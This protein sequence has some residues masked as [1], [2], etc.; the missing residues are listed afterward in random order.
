M[1]KSWEERPR[2]QQFKASE[3]CV[4]NETAK[5]YDCDVAGMTMNELREKIIQEWGQPETV[6]Y[7]VGWYES[8]RLGKRKEE[9]RIL[10]NK[11]WD[12][13][14]VHLLSLC[15]LKKEAKAARVGE[16]VGNQ[17]TIVLNLVPSSHH[18][19]GSYF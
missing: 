9:G 5:S 15:P 7:V 14:R 4:V 10:W 3:R 12:A 8:Q 6:E 13:E 2:I 17:Y 16:R 19:W 18:R 11:L 1:I